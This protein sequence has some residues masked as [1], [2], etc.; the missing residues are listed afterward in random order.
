MP[1]GAEIVIQGQ[2]L[3][4]SDYLAIMGDRAQNLG[5][6]TASSCANLLTQS[7]QGASGVFASVG[8]TSYGD[9]AEPSHYFLGPNGN[10][11]L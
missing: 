5:D 9:R 10:I 7:A 1:V 2:S 8:P 6:I 4:L 3:M 11:C